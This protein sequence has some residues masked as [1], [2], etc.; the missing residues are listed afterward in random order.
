MSATS[1]VY[2]SNSAATSLDLSDSD[3]SLPPI[4][5]DSVMMNGRLCLAD[6]GKGLQP[7]Q[8]EQKITALI[9]AF[10]ELAKSKDWNGE[11]DLDNCALAP[12]HIER[13]LSSIPS[14]QRKKVTK[15]NLS[16]NTLSDSLLISLKRLFPK[17]TH[18][19]LS[20]TPNIWKSN[21]DLSKPINAEWRLELLKGWIDRVLAKKKPS[22]D[23]QKLNK[24]LETINQTLITHEYE[25]LPDFKRSQIGIIIE[26]LLPELQS[27]FANGPD[28]LVT[29]DPATLNQ[30]PVSLLELDLTGSTIDNLPPLNLLQNLERLNLSSSQHL[31][32]IE[33]WDGLGNLKALDFTNC[34]KLYNIPHLRSLPKL[35]SLLLSGCYRR[36]EETW[37]LKSYRQQIIESIL[38]KLFYGKPSKS[39]QLVNAMVEKI[40]TTPTN[41]RLKNT[42]FES[43]FGH[44][45]AD[46]QFQ[47]FELH[48][49]GLSQLEEVDVSLNKS[50]KLITLKGCNSLSKLQAQ[51]C[52][53]LVEVRHLPDATRLAMLSLTDTG[54]VLNKIER[55]TLKNLTYLTELHL[56][57]SSSDDKH[58]TDLK[59]ISQLH[60]ARHLFQTNDATALNFFRALPDQVRNNVYKFI[61]YDHLG[62]NALDNGLKGDS[63]YGERYFLERVS[64]AQ[65]AELIGRHIPAM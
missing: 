26:D 28:A 47:N 14:D 40:K 9:T 18:L 16:H 20:Y 33:T 41:D 64:N 37:Y 65:R 15:L 46:A 19:N 21:S 29:L 49:N 38:D 2:L 54:I 52:P 24:L 22:S 25:K 62:R 32:K 50:L 27:A 23:E 55:G 57:P 12:N 13:I 11:I 42:A 48:C 51:G 39:Q 45:I 61:Y 34:S 44:S 60:K 6:F 5:L 43:F 58:Y 36:T 30:L 3:A 53:K 17:L 1:S 63:K 56:T 59:N 4:T 7:E 35:C 10:A 31:V 8:A